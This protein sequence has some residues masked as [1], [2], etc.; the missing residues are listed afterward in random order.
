MNEVT[1]IA[2]WF[3]VRNLP[4]FRVLQSSGLI[5]LEFEVLGGCLDCQE[6]CGRKGKEWNEL[7]IRHSKADVKNH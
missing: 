5:W 2:F 3:C 4:Y 7:L 6:G 1:G